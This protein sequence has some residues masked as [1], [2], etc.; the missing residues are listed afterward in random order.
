M[1]LNKIFCNKTPIQFMALEK[2]KNK[3]TRKKLVLKILTLALYIALSLYL[4][5]LLVNYGINPL[6][7]SFIILFIVLIT[8]GPFLRRNKQGLYS[9]MFSGSKKGLNQNKVPKMEIKQIEKEESKIPKPINLEFEYRKSLINKCKNCGNIV[10][11][12]VKKCPFCNKNI[13]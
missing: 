8:I 10:P 4:Y 12:F 5:Y 7:I 3:I 13:S 6:I 2:N 1:S 11:N 9:R